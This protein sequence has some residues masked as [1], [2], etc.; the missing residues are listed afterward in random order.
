[1][2]RAHTLLLLLCLPFCVAWTGDG[3]ADVVWATE[4][5]GH[6]RDGHSQ[7]FVKTHT[8]GTLRTVSV[9]YQREPD[10]DVN[11]TLTVPAE[12]LEQGTVELEPSQVDFRESG[13]GAFEDP[14]MAQGSSLTL[15]HKY[16][17]A[18]IELSLEIF[19]GT[20]WQFIN[21]TGL[22]HPPARLERGPAPPS[23]DRSGGRVV[24]AVDDSGGCDGS[25]WDDDDDSDEWIDEYE[26]PPSEDSGGCDSS[27]W[28]DDDGWDDDDDDSDA[29]DSG[30]Y[31]WG[32]DDSG[33]GCDSDDWE[34]DDD[35]WSDSGSDDS[36]GCEGD[37][38]EDDDDSWDDDSSGG[39]VPE[40]EA[41][42]GRRKK[43]SP[44]IKRAVRWI[45]WACVFLSFPLM[46]RR[47]RWR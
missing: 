10:I 33:G 13:D 7:A 2:H 14:Q 34:D 44:W 25:D 47:R 36:A 28:D 15:F 29:M 4:I 37:D 45:P 20:S 9:R 39:C 12:R 8:Y 41:A 46:R 40:A 32:D 42:T 26:P 35:S 23:E 43:R 31:D 22:L 6:R 19:N 30:S 38:W 11:I 1:M 27:D 16:T 5:E 3:S 21:L 17:P 24:V 18:T